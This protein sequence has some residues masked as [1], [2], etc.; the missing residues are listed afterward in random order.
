VPHYFTMA[1]TA[2]IVGGR[3]RTYGSNSRMRAARAR[4]LL[5]RGMQR[6]MRSLRSS[7]RRMPIKLP[8]QLRRVRSARVIQRVVRGGLVRRRM[9][10]RTRAIAIVL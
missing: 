8:S 3:F 1:R 10:G 7:R 2:R 5:R 6:R 9:A 4:N